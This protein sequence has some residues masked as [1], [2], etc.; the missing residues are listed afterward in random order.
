M[1]R[2]PTEELIL[3]PSPTKWFWMT[4]GFFVGGA[5]SLSMISQHQWLGWALI[6]IMSLGTAFSA[7]VPFASRM[8]P[9]L[10]SAGLTFGTLRRRYTYRLS[11]IASFFGLHMG[12]WYNTVGFN[13]SDSF[14]GERGVRRINQEFGRFDRFLP[15]TYGMQPL[16][17]AA[18]L[19]TWRLRNAQHHAAYRRT[20]RER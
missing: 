20:C 14:P 3:R 4:T 16:E 12:S 15:D 18:L 8:R 19:E 7:W 17:L 11:D 9:H 10:S 2:T 6:P 13:F 1:T 5:I